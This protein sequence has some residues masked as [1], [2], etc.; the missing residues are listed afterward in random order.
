MKGKCPDC[1]HRLTL[2]DGKL[3]Y[4]EIKVNR[5]SWAACDGSWKEPVEEKK[6]E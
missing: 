3:P 4:H 6:D 5:Q 2:V 1:N